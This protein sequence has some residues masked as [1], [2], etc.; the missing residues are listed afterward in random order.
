[1]CK[2][3]CGYFH[4]SGFAWAKGVD[5]LVDTAKLVYNFVTNFCQLYSF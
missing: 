1:M 3:F 4:R 2:H 5:T